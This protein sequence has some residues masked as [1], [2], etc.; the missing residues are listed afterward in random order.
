MS[1][2]ARVFAIL[3]L[4]LSVANYTTGEPLWAAAY[5]VCANAYI[6]AAMVIASAR[7]ERPDTNRRE[8]S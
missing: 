5:L 8:G 3:F 1:T 4:A 7:G 6:A 2:T